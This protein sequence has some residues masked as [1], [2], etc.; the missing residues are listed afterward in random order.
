MAKIDEIKESIGYLKVIFSIMIAINI[1]L[2]AWLYK[3][4]E[5]IDIFGTLLLLI[6]SVFISIGIIYVNRSILKK[7]R[8]LRDL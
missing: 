8:S 5:I 7:I 1:S 3:N 2:V 6:L 4:Y